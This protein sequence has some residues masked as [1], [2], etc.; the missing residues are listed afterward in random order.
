MNRPKLLIL[1]GVPCSGKTTYAVKLMGTDPNYV[2][3]SRDFIRWEMEGPDYKHSSGNEKTVTIRF[4]NKLISAADR[5]KSI[6]ID[7][8]NCTEKYL[9][10]FIDLFQNKY[11][12]Y[13]ISIKFFDISLIKALVRNFI[14]AYR[15][16]KYIPFKV[17]KRMHQNYNRIDKTQYEYFLYE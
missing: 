7:N 3:I 17:L 14:R 11:P 13:E 16:N 1:S 12:N 8:T 4:K 6:I 2:V 15:T 5:E 9:N 10:S